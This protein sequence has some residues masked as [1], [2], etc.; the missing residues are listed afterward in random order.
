[1]PT[2]IFIQD[3]KEEIYKWKADRYQILLMGYFNE[4]ILSQISHRF[5]AKVGL[6]ELIKD[7][8]GGGVP[9]TTRS[10]NRNNAI[11]DICGSPGLSTI[12]CRYLSFHYA[13]TLDHRLIWVKISLSSALGDKTL[14]SKDL[15]AQNSRVHNPSG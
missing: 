9:G 13:I 10:N 12:I 1:M 4:Y 3:A 8:H 2:Q 11:D 5:F 15:Y 7:Q 14:P 6:R